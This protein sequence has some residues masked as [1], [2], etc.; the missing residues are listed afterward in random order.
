MV[1]DNA[2]LSDGYEDV[3]EMQAPCAK[4]VHERRLAR[5]SEEAKGKNVTCSE[6]KHSLDN[7][8]VEVKSPARTAQSTPVATG[9]SQA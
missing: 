2:S 3:D 4:I 1:N 8:Y 7:E 5:Q 9:Y 6:C